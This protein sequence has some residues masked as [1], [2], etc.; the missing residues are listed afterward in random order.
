[1]KPGNRHD[2]QG[3]K[4]SKAKALE[5]ESGDTYLSMHTSS[6]NT[7]KRFLFWYMASPSVKNDYYNFFY[8]GT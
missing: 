2:V 8:R 3:A 6:S 5:D 4:S 1:M 7:E